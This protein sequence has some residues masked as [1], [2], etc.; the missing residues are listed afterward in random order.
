MIWTLVTW[1]SLGVPTSFFNLINQLTGDVFYEPLRRIQ[2]GFD[3]DVPNVEMP[4]V[5]F[6][7]LFSVAFLIYVFLIKRVEK[8]ATS[9]LWMILGFAILFRLILLPSYPVHE[10]DFYRY[11]WD[12]KQIKYGVNPFQFAPEDVTVYAGG[13][14]KYLYYYNYAQHEYAW[15]RR[16][17][18]V[19]EKHRLELL[20]LA[21]DDN[22]KWF[23]RI[24]H[25][26]VPTI[27][28]PTAQLVFWL[29]S[30]IAQDSMLFM[31]L[32][33]VLFDLGVIALIVLLLKHFG[34]NPGFVLVYAWSPLILKEFANSGHYDAVAV[35]FM[36]LFLYLLIK[37][38]KWVSGFSFV[39]AGLS[40]YFC[41]ILMPLVWRR[42]GFKHIVVG[43][44]MSVLA[45]FPFLFWGGIGVDIFEGLSIY[46]HLWTFNGALF[47]LI[48][49]PFEW[50]GHS[51]PMLPKLICGFILAVIIGV[52][53]L[54]PIKDDRQLLFKSFIVLASMF[55]LNPVGDP[56]YYSWLVPFLCFFRIRSFI[57][58][59]GL[60]IFS[61]LSFITEW[62]RWLLLIQYVPFYLL[63]IIEVYQRRVQQS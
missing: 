61:Y 3:Y 9:H 25:Q 15:E 29:C 24:G 44:L 51:S 14:E 35:F 12:G 39:A 40:K 59:S 31:K 37:N 28:P 47:T 36:M 21:R 60:L 49:L 5:V 22:P 56:W 26:W 8:Y 23:S 50:S 11:M 53:S 63:L 34:M 62:G 1:V 2:N 27:Y 6:L 43:V 46:S 4:T 17:F 58:L 57:L 16:P 30:L 7:V 13:E 54:K 19:K 10:N 41:F 45:F 18:S 55:L 52:Q 33:F 42:F 20:L 48:R 38:K 32:V